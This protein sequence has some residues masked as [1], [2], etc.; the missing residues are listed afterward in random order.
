MQP[1]AALD[2]RQ[3]VPGTS[4]GASKSSGELDEAVEG[5]GVAQGVAARG[6]VRRG[7]REDLLDRHLELLAIERLRDVGDG[8]DL[9]RDVAR[10]GPLADAPRYLFL[11]VV[12]ELDAL[13]ELH[14]EGHVGVATR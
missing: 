7:A 5:L 6:L 8:E 14:E 3:T 10:G 2:P 13:L 1:K 11:E 4:C 12:V 9:V